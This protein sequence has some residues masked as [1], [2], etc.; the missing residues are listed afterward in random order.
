MSIPIPC[1]SIT[2][3]QMLTHMQTLTIS[4]CLQC[5]DM[6][7]QKT[8]VTILFHIISPKLKEA[9][10][11]FSMFCHAACIHINGS[12]SH[13]KLNTRIQ[14]TNSQPIFVIKCAYTLNN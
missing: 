4:Q 3:A 1:V 14:K 8:A 2:Y 9:E 13:G 5:V 11:Q 12:S 7:E 10:I 6:L